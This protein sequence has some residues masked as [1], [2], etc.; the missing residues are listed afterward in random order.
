MQRHSQKWNHTI[1]TYDCGKMFIVQILNQ[2]IILKELKYFVM[3]CSIPLENSRNSYLG[4]YG[5][6][7]FVVT[8]STNCLD[9]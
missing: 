9:L 3:C 5:L 7:K 4:T 8:D 6:S 1:T 2:K